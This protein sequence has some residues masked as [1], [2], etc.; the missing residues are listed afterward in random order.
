[1]HDSPAAQSPIF[2]VEV[3]PAAKGGR[4]GA[5]TRG[6]GDK[7]R[8]LSDEQMQ[9]AFAVVEKM[10]AQAAA[11]LQTLRAD[12]ARPVPDAMELEFG[13]SFNAELQAYFAKTA[14]E[15]TLSIKLS[16]TAS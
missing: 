5:T 3:D 15:A 1:M 7:L 6:P 14:G 11:T 8:A 4:P 12:G 10:A 13:L 2:L 16:W 9:L